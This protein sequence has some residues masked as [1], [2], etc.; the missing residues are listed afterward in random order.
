MSWKS[1]TE[2][3][4]ARTGSIAARLTVWY[5]LLSVALIASAGSVLY[6]AL[7]DRLQQED[8]RILAGKIAEVR[9]V[10]VLH[11]SDHAALREEVQHETE[12]LP[13]IYIRVLDARQHIVADSPVSGAVSDNH[14]PF[15]RSP[16]PVDDRGRDWF[17]GD[18]KKYRLMSG[19][20]EASSP[21][22]VQAAMSL[23]KEEQ[24]L[25]AYRST[26]L[27][28]VAIFLAIAVAAGYL[29][30]RRGM[31]PVSRLAAIVDELGAAQLHR[32]VGDEPWPL[33]LRPL[34]TNFDRL[35]SR[36][37]DSFARISRFSA[38]IAH[39]LRTPLHILRGEAEIAL[40]RERSNEDYRACIESAMDEYDRLSRMV[41]A[42]LFLARTEQPAAQLEKKWLDLRQEIAVV[43]DFYQAM[44]DEQ[45]VTLIPSGTGTILADA[46]LLR[47]ALGNLVANALHHTASGGRVAIDT[48]T[49]RN[50]VAE[51][52]VSDTG[53]GIA[54]ED[55]PRVL[56]RFYRADGSRSRQGQGTGL[57][58][59]IVQSIMHL[60]GGTISIQSKPDHNTA[61]A[62]TFPAAAGTA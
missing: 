48:K 30:A 44:A 1:G 50:Q 19:K 37:E 7:A 35:L 24:L 62:L 58:L 45:G 10:L 11:P 8:D 31:R 12:T 59:A 54:P 57:G 14:G 32:R 9:A 16:L 42:L 3:A 4:T 29:I 18:G 46:S 33:E 23:A 28:T 53:C 43:C 39:E 38:D 60:H 51:I 17:S 6:W 56:E 27:L 2:N 40:S 22:T 20:F 5:A 49:L 34:A 15:A 61:V 21:F 55:L 25:S 26:L 36:L 13:G 52:T 47:R 41:D